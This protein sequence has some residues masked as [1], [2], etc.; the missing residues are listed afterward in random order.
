M[1][2]KRKLTRVLILFVIA[3]SLAPVAQAAQEGESGHGVGATLL[4]IVVILLAAKASGLVERFGQPP[5]LGELAI[6]VVL[7]NLVLVGL[8]LFEPMKSEP[9]LAFL[10]QLGV[11]ILLFQ[12]C[13]G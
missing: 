13:A 9:L 3:L 4:W 1:R 7:G 12:V 6:G 10:A 11:I 5:V 2:V 8:P